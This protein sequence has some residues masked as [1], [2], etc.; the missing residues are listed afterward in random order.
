M[1]DNREAA[2]RPLAEAVHDAGPRDPLV[3]ALPRGGVPLARIVAERLG[4]A[5]DLVFV[6]KIGMPGQKELA[7]G[8]LV[9][10]AS[11]QTVWNRQVL[12]LGN[13]SEADFDGEIA[14]LLDEI[15]RRRDLYLG[16][17]APEPVE[18]RTAILVDDGIATG[19]TVRAAIAAMRK[20]G[21][22]EV[23]VAV[24]VAPDDT[25]AQLKAEADRVICL[26]TPRPFHAVG[27]HYL[28]F[29]EVT[30][31]DVVRLLGEGESGL[32]RTVDPLPSA[33]KG[34]DEGRE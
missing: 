8:A 31:Q 10:G 4:A 22:Q 13:R 18:G 17:R 29:G 9:D 26:A 5:L 6:R 12:A 16:G 19:A 11:P 21:A 25:L 30:D 20:A 27:V 1:F 7:A 15:A 2:A 23:W 28:D 34:K 33:P 24:P 3:L 14:R 32:P